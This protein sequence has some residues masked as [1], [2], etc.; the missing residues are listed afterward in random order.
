MSEI[1]KIQVDGVIYDLTA[2]GEEFESQ[3]KDLDNK[4]NDI[5][6]KVND[7]DAKIDSEIQKEADR[8]D[9]KINQL[10][11][12][13]NVSINDL[14]TNIAEVEKSVEAEKQ[15]REEADTK[16]QQSIDAI[17]GT[18][19]DVVKYQEFEYQGETRKT[20][21][22]A[23]HDTISGVDTEGNGH[24]LIMLSKWNKADVGSAN[25]QLNLNSTGRPQV[26]DTEEVAYVSDMTNV[27]KETVGEDGRKT[28]YLDNH[29][30]ICGYM[31]DGQTAVNIAMVSK[32]GKVD[33]GST[34][35]ELN[36]NGLSDHPTYNDTEK[37]ALLKDLEGAT[38][39]DIKALEE[40][41][42]GIDTKVDNLNTTVVDSNS[43]INTRIDEETA[44]L[45]TRIDSEVLPEI[46]ELDKNKVGYF[47][48]DKNGIKTK[49]ILLDNYASVLGKDTEGTSHNLIMLSKWNKADVGASGVE[50]NFNGSQTRP[51]YNDDKELAL[52]EDIN[53]T[54]ETINLVK[55]DDLTYELEVGDRIAGTISI[56]KD[57]FLKSVEYLPDTKELKFVFETTEGE[58]VSNIDISDLV[59]I[60]TAGNGLLL[61]G[62][63]FSI[64]LDPST[65]A[66]LEVTENGLR[67]VG[68][69]EELNSKASVEELNAEAEERSKKDTELEE[70]LFGKVDFVDV[71]DQNL[72]NR[73]A[74]VLPS[75][76]DVIL[77]NTEDGGDISLLQYNRWGIVDLGTSTKPIN[78]NT[79]A[80]VRPTVQEAGQSGEE[81]YSIA[82]TSDL[83]DLATKGEVSLKANQSDVDFQVN[84]LNEKIDSINVP[85]KVSELENDS[86]YQTAQD[87]D[88]RIQDLINAAPA[89]LDTLGEI[90]TALKDNESAV[91]A[92]TSELANK[93]NKSEIPTELPNPEALTIKYNGVTA[94]SYDGSKSETGNFIVNSETIPMSEEDATTLSAKIETLATKESLESEASSR[95]N[96]DAEL[97]S[98]INKV[99]NSKLYYPG[100]KVDTQKLFALTKESS[101]DDIKA[102][103]QIK[104]ASGGYTLPT[105]EILDECLGKGYQLLSNW[106]PVSIVW[107]GAAYVFYIVGQNYMMRP[108]GLYTVAI[109]IVDGAYSVFQAAKV[110]EFA[111]T[112]ELSSINEK[113]NSINSSITVLNDKLNLLQAKYDSIVAE[114]SEE[115]IDFQGGDEDINDSTKSFILNNSQITSS[116]TM[117]A[118]SVVINE[119]NLSNDARMKIN[120]GNVEINNLSV[121]G[122]FPKSNGNAVINVNESEYIVFKDMIFDSSDIYNGIE[123]GLNS[124]TLPKNILFENCKF[125]GSFTN[126]AILIFGTSDDAVITLNNCSFESV[127]N[128][129]RLSNKSNAKN[130]TVNIVN[131]TIDKWDSNPMWAGFLIFEDYTSK[132]PEEIAANNLFGDGKIKVNFVNLMHNGVKVL[133]KDLSKVCGTQDENQVVYICQDNAEGDMI[134]AYDE[135]IYPVITFK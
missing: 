21:Q 90:A 48:A 103:L 1:K 131:C 52:L 18:A 55:K 14:T 102:A 24:N 97:E 65:D 118:K 57:Q 110:E 123:I 129:L 11:E 62:G 7:L 46:S 66:Y 76:G 72:P 54:A 22:L 86:N 36:L 32:W 89:E 77:S 60:Y 16:L 112:D 135:S 61:E 15:A 28:I 106:M 79:P 33:M 39:E 58:Q 3:I 128:A 96:K 94:F 100:V 69:K 109:R 95:S 45:N 13:T 107:N 42:D 127:S 23:N 111:N 82:Y 120:S 117:N 49:N 116:T 37:I 63:K 50:L 29:E 88:N 27:V 40:K 12:S 59:D 26:N 43:A 125:T 105:A 74:I 17:T 34:S 84:A 70:K 126:N 101:E 80:G 73:K 25:V 35:V 108:T 2:S 119:A 19:E 87:V 122:N 78:L 132:T 47:E 53:G 93:A 67:L 91:G 133:P 113:I 5:D 38:A 20:I 51:T 56:P 10:N 124:T 99:A 41:V 114:N 83:S 71:A 130:I 81:A 75:Q 115:V 134:A 121:S 31:P 4:V 64:K 92:I 30:N 44:K 9:E 68:L 98:K 8:V 85:T 104:A 6:N